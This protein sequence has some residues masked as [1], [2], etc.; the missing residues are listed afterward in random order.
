M[1]PQGVAP[2]IPLFSTVFCRFQGL[3][4]NVDGTPTLLHIN[5]VGTNDVP[6]VSSAVTLPAS[7]EDIVQTITQAQL[8][9]NATDI[10][11][12]DVLSVLN[13]KVDHGTVA[14][15]KGE[16]Q[17][18]PEANYNGKVTFTY[19]VVDGNGGVVHTS[20]TTDLA[21]VNDAATITQTSIDVKEDTAPTA[22]VQL[23]ITDIDNKN[24]EHFI[25][26]TLQG[27]HGSATLAQDGTLVYTLDNA[28]AQNLAE[29]EKVTDTLQVTSADG[30]TKDVL[31][32][33][34]GTN[35]A[36]ALTVNQTNN[37]SGT[38]KETDVDTTDTH[39]FDT[40][41]AI[42]HYGTLTVDPTTGA[43]SYAQTPSVAGMNYDKA[44][45]VYSGKE[46]FAVEVKDNHGGVDT[47]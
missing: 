25:A 23:G 36:P 4:R 45:G 26:G 21:A 31:V 8:L 37:T 35:D 16:I 27:T 5:V 15:I 39:T 47:K 9:A 12:T 2:D 18:I 33:I 38:L 11:T 34:T 30:T 29:G 24:E 28:K 42:G 1:Y 3:H 43:Y 20:A 6:K 17:F 44:T 7:S 19:D 13:L 10:D 46:V 22:T 40:I 14:F 41:N 32:T